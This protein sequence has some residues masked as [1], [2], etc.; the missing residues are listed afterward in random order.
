M[1]RI[2]DR[3]NLPLSQD[4][5]WDSLMELARIGALPN[6]GNDR[7]TLTDRDAEGRAL[8]RR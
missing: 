6:G 1:V 2:T 5:L 7:Q 8:F 4:R 3:T